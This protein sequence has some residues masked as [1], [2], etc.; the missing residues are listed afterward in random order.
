MQD[1]IRNKYLEYRD[2]II[3]VRRHLHAHPETGDQ[4]IETTEY[5]VERLQQRGLHIERSLPTGLTAV[6]EP[7]PECVKKGACVGI[8]A[9]I[10]A[11]P[12]SEQCDLPFRSQNEGVMHACGHDV[13]TAAAVGAALILSDPDIRPMLT[14][15]VKFI[16]QPAEETDG[17][18]L[19]M[20]EGG[21]LTSPDVD[22]M[23]SFHCEPSLPA[24]EIAVR[25]GYTRA[26]SDM[27]DIRITGKSSH[28]AYPE[29][30][31]DAIAAASAVV[32][33]IHTIVSRNINAFEPCVITIGM[34]HAGTAENIV[35]DEAVLSGT[36]RTVSPDVRE[37]A[38]Q[39]IREVA[40]GTAQAFGARAQVAFRPGYAALMNDPTVTAV[41]RSCGEQMA[42]GEHVHGM[43]QAMMSV[44]DFSFFARELPSVYFFAGTGFPGRENAGLHHGAFEV[45]ESVFDTVVPLE[46]MTA[47]TLQKG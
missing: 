13:H 37:H 42:G 26:S 33:G 9:D 43:E 46:V 30:G 11:L 34:F 1:R 24:G 4:E 19:R 23:V 3:D 38:M 44:D 28:G 39:R 47:L 15:P 12:I 10:D 22:C 17:G 8:R 32:S 29:D 16:F 2:E 31:V 6:L 21:C 35:C 27:F 40:S 36:M 7:D 41:L 25:S 18:A 45:N 14:A 20:I 5:L